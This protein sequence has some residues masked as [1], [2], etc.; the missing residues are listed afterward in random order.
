MEQ[1]KLLRGKPELKQRTAPTILG[2][3]VLTKAL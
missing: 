2:A 3:Y 1:I